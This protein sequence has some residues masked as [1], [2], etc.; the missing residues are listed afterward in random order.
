MDKERIKLLC[1]Q[2]GIAPQKSR[3]QNFLVNESIV[4]KII[5]AAKVSDRDTVLEV[6][7]GL[8]VL[9]E[10]LVAKAKRVVA[11]ELDRKVLELLQA[12]FVNNQDF[13]LVAGDILK[14]NLN[15]LKLANFG[16][17]L[18]SNLPYNITS[19]FLRVVLEN[20]Q[21]KPKEMILMLQ[22]E[23]A[24]RIVAKAG[25]MSV[26]SVMVQFYS[27]PELLFTVPKNDF[28]PEPEVDSAVIL[29]KIKQKLPNI[30]QKKFFQLVKI[31]FSS[32]RK[33][34]QNNLAAG[35]KLKNEEVKNILSGAGFDP[36]VRAEDLSLDDWLKLFSCF[37]L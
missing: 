36:L 16:Y 34:L 6:G 14:I 19:H 8:G 31:G 15:S 18:I 25:E 22:K 13:E 37:T 12:N 17:K 29:F 35:L 32:K 4:D 3:G 21:N 30:D 11:V 1:R 2:Y 27:D 23:V 33:Q 7:P 5:K 20:S 24:E 9:T 28:W 26:L 10:S